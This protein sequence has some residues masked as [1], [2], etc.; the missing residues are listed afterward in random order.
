MQRDPF[1][2]E[3]GAAVLRALA[4]ARVCI[5]GIIEKL[6]NRIECKSGHWVGGGG[7]AVYFDKRTNFPASC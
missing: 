5:R 3:I 1:I 4:Y 2:R 6:I 7:K